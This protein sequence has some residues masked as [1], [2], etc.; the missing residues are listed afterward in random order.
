MLEVREQVRLP[1]KRML[2]LCLDSISYRMFRSTVTVVIIVLAIAFLASIM[3]EG[4]LGRAVRDTVVS[5]AARRTAY[6]RFLSEVSYPESNEDLLRT[7]ALLQPDTATY[8][9]FQRWAALPEPQLAE[10][11]ET[12][13]RAVVFLNFFD[14]MSVGRRALLVEGRRGLEIFGWLSDP[15]NFAVF[16]KRLEPMRSLKVPY[17]YEEFQGFVTAWPAYRRQLLQ[18]KKNY[19]GT[20]ERIAQLTKPQGV[21]GRLSAAATAGTTEDFFASLRQA[22]FRIDEQE[23]PLILEGMAYQRNVSWAFDQLRKDAVRTGWNR[24][25]QEHFSPSHALQSSAGD[26]S[27]LQWIQAQLGADF[28]AARFAAVA[29][30]YDKMTALLEAEQHLLNR[31]GRTQGLSE[32]AMWLIFISFVVCVVGIANAMLMSVL[33][34]FKEIATM[35]C[36]GARN[37]TIGFLFITE[38]T[39]IGVVGGM[40]GM[41]LGFLIVLGRQWW[42]YGSALY[43]NFPWLDM[44][45]TFLACFS[46]ALV[47]S[48]FAAIYP[49]RVAA[50]MAPM[51]AMRVD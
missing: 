14:N 10:F 46:C 42:L 9:N 32:K 19:A 38:S 22:G 31:Y 44:G 16:G 45:V 50:R 47:L 6:S 35:K 28:D 36:L 48:S 26:S 30:E 29:L 3:V 25:F 15:E 41:V 39:I 21:A 49:A 37:G 23:V 13:R 27:R 40:I 24:N 12:S 33:E 34:R 20:I 43:V 18:L 17:S 7:L 5:Q 8:E 51:E 1:F 11:L 2:E 4:Y